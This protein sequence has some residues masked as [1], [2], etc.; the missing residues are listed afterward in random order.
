MRRARV[1]LEARV[2]LGVRGVLVVEVED[3]ERDDA[4]VGVDLGQREMIVERERAAAA[5]D[6]GLEAACGVSESRSPRVASSCVAPAAPGLVEEHP[7]LRD[8]RRRSRSRAA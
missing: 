1:G 7:E 6:L 5:R 4:A 8:E 2:E 3:H